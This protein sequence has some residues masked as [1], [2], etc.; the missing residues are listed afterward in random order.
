MG[1]AAVLPMRAA[2]LDDGRMV[3]IVTPGRPG[4]APLAT[5]I[6]V[7]GEVVHVMLEERHSEASAPSGRVDESDRGER[8]ERVDRATLVG[9]PEGTDPRRDLTMLVTLGGATGEVRLAGD[10]L[11]A[12]VPGQGTEYRPTA[13]WYDERALVLLTW[14]S[15]SCP[16]IIGSIE[17]LRSAGTVTFVTEDRPCTMDMAPRA[18]IID[19]GAFPAV[20]SDGGF[21]LTLV[22]DNLDAAIPVPPA[23]A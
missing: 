5:E 23:R 18:T 15:S 12:G 2:W 14:G 4:R 13:G 11:R 21:T 22:G 7:D 8:A 3:A 10:P 1:E 9:V 17:A 16:P 6:A 19:L 20:R